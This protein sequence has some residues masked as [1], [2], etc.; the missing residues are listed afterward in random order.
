[1]GVRNDEFSTDNNVYVMR[2][3]WSLVQ[4]IR[5]R[6]RHGVKALVQG[7]VGQM[8]ERNIVVGN[9]QKGYYQEYVVE[10]TNRVS[11]KKN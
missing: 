3:E 5:E 6:L 10:N 4:L 7:C 2:L 8:E 9:M 11:R 1:M